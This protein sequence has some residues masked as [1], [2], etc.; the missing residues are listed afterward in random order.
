MTVGRWD[1]IDKLFQSEFIDWDSVSFDD[2]NIDKVLRA[3]GAKPHPDDPDIYLA[4]ERDG[5]GATEGNVIVQPIQYLFDSFIPL[6]SVCLIVAPPYKLKTWLAMSAAV[7]VANEQPWLNRS[8]L[9]VSEVNPFYERNQWHEVFHKTV[10]CEFEKPQEMPRRLS[11]LGNKRGKIFQASPSLQLTDPAFWEGLKKLQPRFV[12]IDSLSR[13]SPDVINENDPRAARPLALAA[14]FSAKYATT[15]FF[16]AHSPK[17]LTSRDLVDVVRGSSAIA[18]A[19]DVVLHID[20]VR[21]P[22]GTDLTERRGKVRCLKMRQGVHQPDP[23]MVRLTDA[24]GLELYNGDSRRKRPE[25]DEEKIYEMIVNESGCSGD[26]I[27]KTLEIRRATVTEAIK[28]L[29]SDGR[30]RREGK[31]PATAHFPVVEALPEAL[32]DDDS[33]KG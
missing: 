16:V 9:P 29:E 7:A 33:R 24:R 23:F 10:W 3:A 22:P 32:P 4:R 31:G 25:S 6:G 8:L 26:Y 30:V 1:I 21:F 15:F 28:K 2:E 19:A 13:G 17:D 27:A 12:G 18:A 20:Q 5:L 11:L 14:E